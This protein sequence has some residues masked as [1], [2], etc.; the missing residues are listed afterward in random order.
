MQKSLYIRGGLLVD[1]ESGT[2][3]ASDLYIKN[4]YITPAPS[5]IPADAVIIDAK[6]LV[7]TPGLI[8]V[9]VHLR[10]PGNE[11]AETIDSGSKT[12][13]KGGFTSIVSMPNTDP[14]TDSPELVSMIKGK[15]TLCG[16]VRVMP[17]GCITKG[18][19]GKELADLE[20][21]A[22]SGAVAFTDDGST[23]TSDTI[24]ADGMRLAAK[25]EKP[26][27]DHALDPAI[28]AKGVMHDGARS[29]QLSLPGIPSRAESEIVERD[30]RL[31]GKTGCVVHIQHVST[32]ESVDLIRRAI[33]MGLK[34]SG[35][36]TPHHLALTDE[37]V[38]AE[39][40]NFKMNPP[41]RS[42]SDRAA[43]L[44]AVAD[45]TISVLATD[46]A[47]H[48]SEAKKKSFI[49]APF[50]IIGLE[51]A[52]GITY[53]LLVKSG[54][55]TLIEWLRRWTTGPARVLGQPAPNLKYGS[56]A[57]ITIFDLNSEWTVDSRH[58]ISKSRNM[59][60]NGRRLTGKAVYTILKGKLTWNATL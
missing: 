6:D 23:V 28:A 40:A 52:V 18:R 56:P 34:V 58:F 26:V 20:G 38:L 14:A 4:G 22:K 27:L 55:M 5:H 49:T 16:H 9:H 53:N 59:P 51:T 19:Q 39:D 21:M 37:E 7:V 43:I 42:V 13:A 12:A 36:A 1:P 46:H 10:E 30:I 17:S 24:M 48:T 2:E 57:D 8:D 25:L 11:A 47:P 31:A 33:S 60:F 54:K 50:G 29:R 45:G 41:V 35:E 3:E 32:S 44:S 15:G